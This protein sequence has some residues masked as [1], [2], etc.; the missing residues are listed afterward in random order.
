MW[1]SILA[2][3]K[4]GSAQTPL[5]PAMEFYASVVYSTIISQKRIGKNSPLY[6]WLLRINFDRYIWKY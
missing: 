5:A 1:L 2:P 4:D 6:Q 3:T